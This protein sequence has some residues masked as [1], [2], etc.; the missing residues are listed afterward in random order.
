M[1]VGDAWG[2]ERKLEVRAAA[3]RAL[4]AVTGRVLL[5]LSHGL[6]ALSV[7]TRSSRRFPSELP[8]LTRARRGRE[9]EGGGR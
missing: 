4:R 6:G 9:E 5:S 7:G 2:L 3:W 1:G 8:G